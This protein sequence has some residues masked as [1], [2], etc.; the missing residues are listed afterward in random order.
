[1]NR[2]QTMSKLNVQIF[3]R[4]VTR[5]PGMHAQDTRA[6]C[7]ILWIRPVDLHVLFIS[8]YWSNMYEK[9][10]ANFSNKLPFLIFWNNLFRGKEFE[11]KSF[12]VLS[13]RSQIWHL[14]H[15]AKEFFWG[16][17]AWWRLGRSPLGLPS[18][19][20]ERRSRRTSWGLHGQSSRSLSPRSSCVFLF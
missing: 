15:R 17:W 7:G 3:D 14:L 9:S 5:M 4:S 10:N 8:I 19:V 6:L 11:R 12:L 1:M 18:L 2:A 13:Q 20:N 16:A